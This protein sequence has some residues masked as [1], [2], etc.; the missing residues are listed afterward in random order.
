M[1]LAVLSAPIGCR[2]PCSSE[3]ASSVQVPLPTTLSDRA[4][5]P[6]P[7]LFQG[8]HPWPRRRR[9]TSHMRGTWARPRRP[10]GLARALRTFDQKHLACRT[11]GRTGR[12][13]KSASHSRGMSRAAWSGSLATIVA[14][15]AVRHN[16]T[17]LQQPLDYLFRPCRSPG[18]ASSPCARTS[19][20]KIAKR[21][22]STTPRLHGTPFRSCG[23]GS[24]SGPVEVLAEV[25]LRDGGSRFLASALQDLQRGALASPAHRFELS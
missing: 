21:G 7:T 17:R 11:S 14:P 19:P 4:E 18:S 6:R 16:L 3:R 15:K 23:P 10:A 5:S 1:L 20:G 24:G 12:R 22:N 9:G 25:V 13:P 8:E 2:T